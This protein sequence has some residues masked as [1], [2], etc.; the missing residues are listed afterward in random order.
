[1]ISGVVISEPAAASSLEIKSEHDSRIPSTG[2]P[3]ATHHENVLF[4][5]L[6]QVA[7]A[8]VIAVGIY[9]AVNA[10]YVVYRWSPQFV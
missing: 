1:M 10:E 7:E 4:G 2:V 5:R 8:V 6:I 3:I 9:I